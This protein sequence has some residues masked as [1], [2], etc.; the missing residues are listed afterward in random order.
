MSLAYPTLG[1][2]KRLALRT[3]SDHAGRARRHPAGAVD[4]PARPP[5][6]DE[7]SCFQCHRSIGRISLLPLCLDMFIGSGCYRRFILLLYIF[8]HYT[9]NIV[10]VISSDLY[11]ERAVLHDACYI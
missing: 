8:I 6:A 5:E 9:R 10:N 3:G 2:G 4:E 7:E 1:S 11:M